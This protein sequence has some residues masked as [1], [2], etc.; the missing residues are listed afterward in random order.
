MS[1]YTLPPGTDV[2]KARVAEMA[3]HANGW[4]GMEPE[5]IVMT[6]SALMNRTLSIEAALTPLDGLASAVPDPLADLATLLA[7]L[8]TDL[9]TVHRTLWPAL[10]SLVSRVPAALARLA[11]LA[12]LPPEV[13]GPR[14]TLLQQCGAEMSLHGYLPRSE[15]RDVELLKD[16]IVRVLDAETRLAALAPPKSESAV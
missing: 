2:L 11:K 14:L 9:T 4:L 6:V 12:G 10:E 5:Q 3:N 7:G 13:E 1:I 16:L 15:G 8:R